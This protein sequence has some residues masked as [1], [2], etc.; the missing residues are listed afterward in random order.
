MGGCKY[1][2]KVM[3]MKNCIRDMLNASGKWWEIERMQIESRK[4]ENIIRI[5]LK[6]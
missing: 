5:L 2:V 1:L 4:R 6:M 3:K